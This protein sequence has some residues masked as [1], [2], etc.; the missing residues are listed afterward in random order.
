[1]NNKYIHG[2]NTNQY[3]TKNNQNNN[4]NPLSNFNINNQ[5]F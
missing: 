5:R 1:M 2:L 4:K 3:Q